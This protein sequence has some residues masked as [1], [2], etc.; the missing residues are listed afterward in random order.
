[1]CRNLY[2]R[3]V[4]VNWFG[5]EFTFHKRTYLPNLQ[6]YLHQQFPIYILQLQNLDTFARDRFF[7]SRPKNGKGE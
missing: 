1:M 2:V 7:T 4:V 6:I 3:G 5:F